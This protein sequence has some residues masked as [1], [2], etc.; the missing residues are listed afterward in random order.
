MV[1]RR[2]IGPSPNDPSRPTPRP[3]ARASLLLPVLVA[4]LY[5]ICYS[6]IRGGLPY[7]PALRFAAMRAVLSGLTLLAIV[8]TLR[9]RLLPPRRVWGGVVVLGFVAT[10]TGF[11]AMFLSLRYSGAGIAS[12][13]GNTTPLLV[14]LL[15]AVFLKEPI[16]PATLGALALGLSGAGLIAL[17]NQSGTGGTGLAGTLLP[18]LAAAANA[19]ESVLVKR[20]DVGAAVLRVVAWQM[21]VGSLPLFLLSFWMEGDEAITWAPRLVWLLVLIAVPG[22]ALATSLWYWLVQHS[23]VGRLSLFL[24]LIPI[25]GLLLAIVAF[26]ERPAGADLAGAMLVLVGLLL[27]LRQSSRNTGAA[28]MPANE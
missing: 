2:R 4:A 17:R 1:S 11:A 3:G 6:A 12:V 18:L 20:L 25:L 26:G 5:A 22:T 21:L 10:G 9:Q 16:G 14:I 28:S 7:A 15:A 8:L 13:L 23:E 19:T 24:F 27:T